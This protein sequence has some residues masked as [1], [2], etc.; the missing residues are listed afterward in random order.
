VVVDE[1]ET[2]QVGVWISCSRFENQVGAHGPPKTLT[3]LSEESQSASRNRTLEHHEPQ[4]R[5]TNTPAQI[6]TQWVT[7]PVSARVRAMRT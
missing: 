5:R 4:F 1:E 3:P 2:V 7:Q 6:H